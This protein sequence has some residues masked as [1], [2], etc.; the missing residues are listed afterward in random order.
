M[1][2]IIEYQG[3]TPSN[4]SSTKMTFIGIF[5][6]DP[7]VVYLMFLVFEGVDYGFDTN[8]R[9]SGKANQVVEQMIK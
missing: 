3:S 2:V 6:V 5:L 9:M 8:V 7:L 1:A 4:S